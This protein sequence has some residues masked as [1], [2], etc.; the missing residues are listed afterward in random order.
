M[1]SGVGGF[2]YLDTE[3]CTS[4][5]PS[6]GGDSFVISLFTSA[7]DAAGN[8]WDVYTGTCVS[9]APCPENTP[10]GSQNGLYSFGGFAAIP[11][12]AATTLNIGPPPDEEKWL[13]FAVTAFTQWRVGGYLTNSRIHVCEQELQGGSVNTINTFST[14]SGCIDIGTGSGGSG[15]AGDVRLKYLIAHELGHAIGYLYA[16]DNFDGA[17]SYDDNGDGNSSPDEYNP[18]L[19]EKNPSGTP[20]IEDGFSEQACDVPRDTYNLYSY[21]WNALALREAFAHL[22]ATRVFNDRAENAVFVWGRNSIADTSGTSRPWKHLNKTRELLD[23]G[24]D[25]IGTGGRIESTLSRLPPTPGSLEPPCCPA[26]KSWTAT[27]RDGASTIRDWT[28]AL[29]NWYTAHIDGPCAPGNPGAGEVDFGE[30]LGV[31]A[32][33]LALFD[34]E[35]EQDKAYD[36]F[37]SATVWGVITPGIPTCSTGAWESSADTFGANN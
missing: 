18:R 24:S 23:E 15:G 1:G 2:V 31:F 8:Q 25:L 26:G 35:T 36:H 17:T 4:A 20:W 33:A 32:I 21:E 6:T 27:C 14:K 12:N 16:L 19:N 5:L 29:W 9:T 22:V 37:H 7:R 3:G 13:M 34:D 30:V 28:G 10:G 11:A